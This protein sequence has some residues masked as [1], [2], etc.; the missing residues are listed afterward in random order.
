MDLTVKNMGFLLGGHMLNSGWGRVCT[1]EQAVVCRYLCGAGKVPALS[2]SFLGKIVGRIVFPGWTPMP[3]I[4][5]GKRYIFV[6]LLQLIASSC[7]SK[8]LYHEIQKLP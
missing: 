8:A 4:F 7:S 1:F 5:C 2:F 6:F 3:K